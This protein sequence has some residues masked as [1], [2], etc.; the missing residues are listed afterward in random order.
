MDY[1]SVLSAFDSEM[2]VLLPHDHMDIVL[3]SHSGADHYCYE[4]GVRTSWRELADKPLPTAMSPVRAVLWGEVPFYLSRDALRDERFHFPGALDDPI[5]AAGLKSRII[6]PLRVQARV[7]G[8]LN[9]SRQA[10]D[11]Y[12]ERDV[13][14]AEQSA[15]LIAPYLHALMHSEEARKAAH[16]ESAAKSREQMLRI[17]ALR[18]TEGMEN[19]RRRLAMDLHDQTL[20]DLARLSRMAA[21]IRRPLQQSADGQML[22]DFIEF[23][24]EIESCLDE[25]R[26]IVD[27]LRPGILEL[28]GFAEAVEEH[29]RR[30]VRFAV[31]PIHTRIEDRAPGLADALD[32]TTRIAVY[33]IIQEAANNAAR[34]SGASEISV[35]IDAVGERLR[36]EVSDDG[37]GCSAPHEGGGGVSHMRTR[38]ALISAE[39]SIASTPDA[40]S[41]VTVCL[42]LP[43]RPSLEVAQ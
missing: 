34:H 2:K 18:L 43:E 40:G 4:V 12:D 33:R 27:D 9:I 10:P 21:R 32:E 16:A 31:P 19:E 42:P 26:R 28:F 23:E 17:G 37:R 41:R 15:D 13:E 30:C 24:D 36:I 39:F 1:E 22:L 25:L 3:L 38:A 11:A 6:I 5:F 14:L 35:T 20:A 8:S 7:I 29:L